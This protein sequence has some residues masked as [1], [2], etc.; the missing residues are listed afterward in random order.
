MTFQ[1][2]V[3][4]QWQLRNS[5]GEQ[6]I[7]AAQ[8]TVHGININGIPLIPKKEGAFKLTEVVVDRKNNLPSY[9]VT[10]IPN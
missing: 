10:L 5:T 9:A 6:N 8:V 4:I 2:M 3:S 7:S 1:R